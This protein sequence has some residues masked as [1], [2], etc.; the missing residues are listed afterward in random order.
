MGC[1][2]AKKTTHKRKH[3]AKAKRNAKKASHHGTTQGRGA[4]GGR[5]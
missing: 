4:R 3:K 5:S 2:K 1:P